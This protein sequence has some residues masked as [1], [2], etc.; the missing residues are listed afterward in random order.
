MLRERAT[1]RFCRETVAGEGMQEVK[2]HRSGKGPEA[3]VC[4]TMVRTR[5]TAALPE[6]LDR[7]VEEAKKGS[8]PHAKVL[9]AMSGLDEVL[10]KDD[11]QAPQDG[12]PRQSLAGLLMKELKRQQST[13]S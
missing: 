10:N 7:F 9:T 1:G 2:L 11:S 6:I 13:Q 5:V 8:V 12:R 4:R 3:K